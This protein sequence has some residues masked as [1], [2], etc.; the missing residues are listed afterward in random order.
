MQHEV[1]STPADPDGPFCRRARTDL[2][3]PPLNNCIPAP[4]GTLS[5]SS[6][7]DISRGTVLFQDE[8]AAA[9]SQAWENDSSSLQHR[10]GLSIKRSVRDISPGAA[11]T[12]RRR[13]DMMC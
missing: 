7:R 4:E 10:R 8:F 9:S 13:A 12:P 2:P 5:T 3:F 1:A 6:S 11:S